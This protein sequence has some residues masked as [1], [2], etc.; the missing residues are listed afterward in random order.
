MEERKI[1]FIVWGPHLKWLLEYTHLHESWKC[2]LSEEVYVKFH[3]KWKDLAK[4][5]P[6]SQIA[7]QQL[8]DH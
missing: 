6:E 1:S 8:S 3:F 2:W 5:K 4:I 7:T